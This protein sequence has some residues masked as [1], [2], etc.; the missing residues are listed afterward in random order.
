MARN[1]MFVEI[2]KIHLRSWHFIVSAN[3]TDGR[4][5]SFEWA[6]D[7]AV[8][9]WGQET[10]SS[11]MAQ[12]T[13]GQ[14]WQSP[15]MVGPISRLLGPRHTVRWRQCG[16]GKGSENEE[17]SDSKSEASQGSAEGRCVSSGN[18]S[19]CNH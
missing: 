9:P 6:W 15:F 16:Y 19:C 14:L 13:E 3:K 11:V 18:A 7:K 12:V 4:F 5:H 8:S 1:V 10:G 17:P 2:H